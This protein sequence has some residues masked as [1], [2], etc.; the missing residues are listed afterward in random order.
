MNLIRVP[1]PAARVALA[2]VVAC[3]LADAEEK[4][5]P[6][7]KLFAKQT[8]T[9]ETETVSSGLRVRLPLTPTLR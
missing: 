7:G 6:F 3:N 4:T 1:L 2:F 9:P 8:V 5:R